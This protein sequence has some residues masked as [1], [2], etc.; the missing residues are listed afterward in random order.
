MKNINNNIE[1]MI[2]Q[3]VKTKKENK[4]IQDKVYKRTKDFLN[5]M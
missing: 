1:K 2:D 5:Q 4:G 3:L